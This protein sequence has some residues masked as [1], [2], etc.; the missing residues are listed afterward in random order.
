M[1][2]SMVASRFRSWPVCDEIPRNAMS[3]INFEMLDKLDTKTLIRFQNISDFCSSFE[4]N[5]KEKL[6]GVI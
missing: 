1:I 6:V 3:S 5:K 4:R 2:T